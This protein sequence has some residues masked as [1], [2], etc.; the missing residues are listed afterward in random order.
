RWSVE[1]KKKPAYFLKKKLCNG[2]WQPGN[3][4]APISD[5]S[6]TGTP[7]N[8]DFPVS[9]IALA[10]GRYWVGIS[11]SD[12][13]TAAWPNTPQRLALIQFSH[14]AKPVRKFTLAAAS[15]RLALFSP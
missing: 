12:N 14:A 4:P 1:K 6:L 11:T 13:S 5:T 8:Y 9:P 7:A 2:V 10:P 15:G 3:N